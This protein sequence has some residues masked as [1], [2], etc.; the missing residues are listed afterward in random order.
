[1]E[2]TAQPLPLEATL[3]HMALSASIGDAAAQRNPLPFNDANMT[4][5]AHIF[6]ERCAFCH[7][8]PQEPP[9]D[10]SRGMFPKPPQ[11][12]EQD[13]MVTADS[14]GVTCWKVTHGIR[15]SGMPGFRSVLSD[16]QRWQVT[17]LVAHAHQ[18]SPAVRAA[19]S[20]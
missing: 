13:Q 11:L 17:M 8:L 12:F 7:G 15:L 5:G 9:T 6:K 14:E 10:A 4:A 1:M 2:T 18:R 3:A 20:P 16:T 19:L